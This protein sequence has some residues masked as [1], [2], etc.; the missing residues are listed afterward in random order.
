M[1]FSKKCRLLVQRK[2]TENSLLITFSSPT[3]CASI[4]MGNWAWISLAAAAPKIKRGLD[5][6]DLNKRVTNNKMVAALAFFP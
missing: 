5:G 3:R 2:A 1:N 4:T 6:N